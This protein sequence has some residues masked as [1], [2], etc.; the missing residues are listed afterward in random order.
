MFCKCGSEVGESVEC[1]EEKILRKMVVEY[2]YM[3]CAFWA[4]FVV[5]LVDGGLMNVCVEVWRVK[6]L[7]CVYC[8][9]V[10]VLLGCSEL[11]CKKLYYIWCV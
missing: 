5:S 8:K 4:S 6:S 11:R 1:F 9:K 2:C 7:K 3:M 10:G